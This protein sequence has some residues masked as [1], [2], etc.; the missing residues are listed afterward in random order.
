MPKL[1][2]VCTSVPPFEIS[3]EEAS[4]FVYR[5]FRKHRKDMDRLMPVFRNAGIMRRYFSV[6]LEWYGSDHS[7]EERNRIYIESATKLG[8]SSI[9]ALF[10]RTGLTRA[11]IDGIFYVNTT[12][13]ATPSIDARLVNVLD[14]RKNIR[15]TPIWG[16][17]CAGGAAGLRH[18]FDY[19]VGHPKH[20][21]LVVAVELCGLTFVPDDYSKSN[22]V[23]CA[24]FGE[25]AAA[26]LLCGD[27][28]S[29]SGPSIIAVQ[30]TFYPDSLEIMGWDIT[31]RG[32]QV[33]FNKRI[34]QLVEQ[35]AG[36]ELDAFLAANN[37]S[38]ADIAHFLYHPGGTKVVSAYQ[39][40]YGRD[41]G[42]F[43]LS[44]EVLA[45]YGNMSSVTVLFVIERF[46]RTVRS[47]ES[48]HAV[49]SALGPGFCSESLLMRY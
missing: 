5:L 36:P 23:A 12:G 9:R 37:L 35:Q 29:N 1:S 40:A 48:K 7:L 4:E 21:V 45:N 24:L 15:R 27:E 47:E 26:A 3:Q 38:H 39:S 10:T 2:A 41:D 43:D 22:V 20:R 18:A 49:I 31:S 33:V 17:G 44:L 34:P 19:L 14:L 28:V 30:S 6:P 42:S 11:D 46:L 32:M 16:L 13:L 8:E 25:G